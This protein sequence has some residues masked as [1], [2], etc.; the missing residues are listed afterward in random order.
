MVNGK[1]IASNIDDI[2]DK[3]ELFA[4]LDDSKKFK[5]LRIFGKITEKTSKNILVKK[6]LLYIF[7]I[8]DQVETKF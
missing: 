8:F 2:K 6:F 3:V 4:F 1:V 5:N 7:I